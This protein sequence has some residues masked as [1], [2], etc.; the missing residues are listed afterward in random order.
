LLIRLTN[1]FI[2]ETPLEGENR[3]NSYKFSLVARKPTI[4]YFVH[5]IPPLF[6]IV[7]LTNPVHTLK[8]DAFNP[9]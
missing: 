9:F 5:S 1:N 2:E 6:P 3:S 8:H 7:S 4:H